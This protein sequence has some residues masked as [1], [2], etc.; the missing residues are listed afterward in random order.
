MAAR[1]A[2]EAGIRS[3]DMTQWGQGEVE[4][5]FDAIGLG[6]NKRVVREHKID[7]PLMQFMGLENFKQLWLPLG[8]KYLWWVHHM[9]VTPVG[10]LFC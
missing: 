8:Q 2:F 3:G 9:P 10:D 7:G 5:L 4:L 1:Q 6:A